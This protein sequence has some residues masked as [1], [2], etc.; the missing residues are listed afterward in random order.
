MLLVCFS[1]LNNQNMLSNNSE[2]RDVV[3]KTAEVAQKKKQ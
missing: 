1:L 3:K 2:K